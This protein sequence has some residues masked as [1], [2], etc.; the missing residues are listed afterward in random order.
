MSTEEIL[1]EVQNICKP[2]NLSSELLYKEFNKS[3]YDVI[4]S[5]RVPS[6]DIIDKVSKEISKIK[7]VDRVLLEL[8]EKK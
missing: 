5:G 8:G 7:E 6:W 3:V 4:L 2:Y 1:N